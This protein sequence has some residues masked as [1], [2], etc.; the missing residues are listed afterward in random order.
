M[1]DILF[2]F[3]PFRVFFPSVGFCRLKHRSNLG[4]NVSPCRAASHE[5][6]LNLTLPVAPGASYAVCSFDGNH[7]DGAL[8]AVHGGLCPSFRAVRT[9]IPSTT[10]RRRSLSA[11]AHSPPI[12]GPLTASRLGFHSNPNFLS[13][14]PLRRNWTSISTRIAEFFGICNRLYAACSSSI[15]RITRN[16]CV[17]ILETSESMKWSRTF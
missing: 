16:G 7:W 9:F 1:A 17:R 11:Q 14:P 10:L 8:G 4:S 12:T 3:L 15:D 5:L 2:A 13:G 6:R